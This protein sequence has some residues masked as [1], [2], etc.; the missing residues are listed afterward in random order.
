MAN[1]ASIRT[2]QTIRIVI[3]SAANVTPVSYTALGPFEIIEAWVVNRVATANT[4]TVKNGAVTLASIVSAATVGDVDYAAALGTADI[5][6]LYL[7][8]TD[9]LSVGT[10]DAAARVEVFLTILPGVTA[11][12]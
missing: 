10:S 12:T 7:N 5:T 9:V 2:S 11:A 4:T 3:D 8:A 1:R 6:K